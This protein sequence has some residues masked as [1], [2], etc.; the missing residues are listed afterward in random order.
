MRT[1]PGTWEQANVPA[2]RV[3]REWFAPM[4]LKAEE[5]QMEI[6][7]GKDSVIDLTGDLMS[8]KREMKVIEKV[9]SLKEAEIGKQEGE[10]SD[11]S[12]PVP[13]RGTKRAKKQK[14]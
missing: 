8:L 11:V 12:S 6:K 10:K 7:E 13:K 2:D 3:K 5:L 14:H 1:I 9:K 4:L